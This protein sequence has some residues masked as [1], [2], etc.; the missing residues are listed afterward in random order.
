MDE[1]QKSK[2][3]IGSYAK[4]IPM[5]FLYSLTDVCAEFSKELFGR[6]TH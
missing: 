3:G 5:H 2:Y 6:M 1:L 4:S